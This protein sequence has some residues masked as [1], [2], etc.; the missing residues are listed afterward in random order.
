MIRLRRIAA[1]MS[2]NEVVPEIDRVTSPRNEV[3]HMRVARQNLAFAV[4][5]S[6]VLNLTKNGHVNLERST[7]A[8]KEELIEVSWCSKHIGIVSPDVANPG[9]THQ[10]CD[11]CMK[12]AEAKHDAWL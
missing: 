4:E 11:Q 12:F 9:A 7:L 10:I 2:E 3:I 1:C 8:A 5:A 6:S